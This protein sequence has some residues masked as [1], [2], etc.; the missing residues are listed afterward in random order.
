MPSLTYS[1]N[2]LDNICLYSDIVDHNFVTTD[3]SIIEKQNILELRIFTFF[4]YL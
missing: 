4:L 1:R 2:N 3:P